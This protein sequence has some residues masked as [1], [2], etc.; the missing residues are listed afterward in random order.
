MAS[1]KKALEIDHNYSNAFYGIGRIQAAR[2]EFKDSKLSFQR[3]IELNPNHTA[4]LFEQSKNI[5]SNQEA[6]ELAEKSARVNR[7]A[8]DKRKESMLEFALANL[9]HKSQKY[10]IAAHHL[11]KAS[12][13]KL[14]I[15]PSDL[16]TNILLTEQTLE[17]TSQIKP[18][19]PKHGSGRIFIIGVPRCGSTLLESVLATNPSI[20]DLGESDAMVKAFSSIINNDII[21]GSKTYL[22]DEYAKKINEPSGDY[23]HSVDKNLYNFRFTEAIARALPAAKIIHCRRHPLDNILSMLRS[24]LMTGHSYTS[25]PSDAARFLIHHEKVM[26]TFKIDYG[27]HI[28]TF[29]YEKFTSNPKRSLQP[30]IEWLGLEWNDMYLQPEKSKRLIN[31]ASVIQARQPINNRSVG[32]WINYKEILE[33]AYAILNASGLFNL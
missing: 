2:G 3:A 18:G 30:L 14:T 28:F 13:L 16:D 22:S 26:K 5:Q 1:H 25:D 32:G 8:L 31:T 11:V 23:T 27:S 12:E 21:G 17:S 19:K 29:D 15:Q 9:N 6:A 10:A 20:K 7:T 24:N 33:P 4:A